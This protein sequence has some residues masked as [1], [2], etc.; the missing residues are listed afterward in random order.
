MP[1]VTNAE[2]R[3][4]A[5]DLHRAETTGVPIAPPS[6]A[7][8]DF[9][10][11]DA[12][13]VQR[14]NIDRRLRAGERAVGHKVGLTSRAMQQMLGVD[15]PDFGVVTDALV[16]S[17]GSHLDVD[18]LIA[19]RVEAE[20]AF[21]IGRTLSPFP[22]RD[23]IMHSIVGVS[24][25]L[26]VIDTRVAEWRIALVDTVADNASCARVVFGAF[27]PATPELIDSLPAAVVS[28]DENG[29]ERVSG[30]GAAVLGHPLT[31]LTWLA[32]TLGG[33]GDVFREG[34]VILAG[35]VAAAVPL[36]ADARYTASAAGFG[37]V[38]LL[39]TGGTGSSTTGAER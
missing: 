1:P 18:A 15:S 17:N 14:I 20:F 10:L 30:A 37:A 22:D 25:A 8:P 33:V 9:T 32:T 31:A 23:E 39:T 24:V 2:L 34:D 38:E 5:D 28:L 16:L 27:L 11:E 12:Y 13:R 4:I 26:E 36:V 7:W 6:A 21:R 35:A 29:A 19:P 3:R